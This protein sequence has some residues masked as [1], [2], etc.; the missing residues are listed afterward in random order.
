M[1]KIRLIEE[2]T[3]YDTPYGRVYMNY[4]SKNFVVRVS[5]GF[6]SAVMLYMLAKSIHDNG[7]TGVV[8]PI[9][10]RRKNSSDVRVFD[11]VDCYP[12]ADSIIDWVRSEFPDVTINDSVKLDAEYW[13]LVKKIDGKNKGSYTFN[14]QLLCEYIYWRYVSV[15]LRDNPHE[16][17]DILRYCEYTGTTKNPPIDANGVPQSD[18]SHR[19]DLD[20]N[21]IEAGSVTTVEIGR[22]DAYIEPFRNADKRM[23]FWLADHL[24]ILDKVM[25]LSR[26]CE[27]DPFQTEEFTKECSECWWCLEK[28][29]AANNYK[30]VK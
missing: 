4:S 22:N 15:Y 24:G 3:A 20:P 11:R 1:D 28:E 26:S 27:G 12:Y 25:Q 18:E 13:W 19:D 21:T 30:V 6:D 29:W 23:T 9:T 2:S 5:G 16:N 14:Q 17:P 7:Q 8:M 10:I